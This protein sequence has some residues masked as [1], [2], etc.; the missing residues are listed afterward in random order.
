[1]PGFDGV[2]AAYKRNFLDLGEVG[3]SF[4]AVHDGRMVVDLW[5]GLADRS[6]GRPWSEDT[7]Q[8]I[9]SG[10]KG[11]VALCLLMLVDRG[12]LDPDAPV[13]RYWPEFAAENKGSIR[14]SDIASHQARLPGVTVPLSEDDILNGRRM[15]ALLAAQAQEGDPRAVDAYHAITYGWLC[16]E[17]IR[18][19]DGRSIGEFFADEVAKPLGLEVWFGLPER[20]EL[21]VSV[22]HYGE[23]W[24]PFDDDQI[25]NDELFARVWANPP[26]FPRTHLPWNTRAY[27]AAEIP[28]AGAIGTARSLARLYGCLARGGEL[29][30]TRLVSAQTLARGCQCLTRRREPLVDEPEAFGFGFELQTENMMLGPPAKAFGHGG[31]GGSAHG[32]WPRQGVGFSYCMNEMREYQTVDPRPKALLSAL[33]EAVLRC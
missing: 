18:R 30:G 25:A 2:A 13:S 10:S 15:A 24:R 9:F 33:H 8:V 22:L 6:T 19:V 20:H 21:R 14:V 5:G 17:L 26:V 32:A 7:L 1:M 27:H 12:A 3:A 16:G 29:D 4:A 28:A 23:A 31:A 11:L